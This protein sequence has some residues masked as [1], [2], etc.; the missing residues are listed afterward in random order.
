MIRG[1]RNLIGQMESKIKGI[2]NCPVCGFA[3]RTIGHGKTPRHGHIKWKKGWLP[4]CK[5]SGLVVDEEPKKESY[6][7]G[8]GVQEAEASRAKDET[9]LCI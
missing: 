2:G 4:P 6:P 9:S 8:L 1:C 3:C 5:G 7:N